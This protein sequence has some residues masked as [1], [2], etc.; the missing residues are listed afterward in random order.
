MPR[1]VVGLTGRLQNTYTC[2]TRFDN[3]NERSGKVRIESLLPSLCDRY[4]TW[5]P[6]VLMSYVV[7]LDWNVHVQPSPQ[8]VE[9][10]TQTLVHAAQEPGKVPGLPFLQRELLPVMAKWCVTNQHPTILASVQR[11]R[12]HGQSGTA[13]PSTMVISRTNSPTRNVFSASQAKEPS[14]FSIGEPVLTMPERAVFACDG[15]Q[16]WLRDGFLPA[17]YDI[18]SGTITDLDWPKEV[19]HYITTIAVNAECV[20]FGTGG[21]GLLELDKR[22]RRWPHY[23]EKDG[24]IHSKN[25]AH[26]PAEHRHWDGYCHRESGGAGL[27]Y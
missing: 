26:Y 14:T 22:T 10:L 1:E 25:S 24:L 18:T 4:P 16:I 11:L 20:W 12:G 27:L 9:R 3:S 5:S 7:W 17:I 13:L 2:F 8:T 21:S 23:T 19:E 15:G 6:H